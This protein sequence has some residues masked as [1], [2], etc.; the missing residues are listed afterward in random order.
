MKKFLCLGLTAA[1]V[2]GMTGCGSKADEPKMAKF[3]EEELTEAQ[4]YVYA[5]MDSYEIPDKEED[6]KEARVLL[7]DDLAADLKGKVDINAWDVSEIDAIVVAYLGDKVEDGATT[8]ADADTE[9]DWS[10]VVFLVGGEG[11]EVSYTKS[12]KSAKFAAT[13]VVDEAGDDTTA[14]A[15]AKKSIAQAQLDAEK[16]L[17]TNKEKLG[18]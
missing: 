4:Q 2:L 8:A 14:I 6:F 5:A 13:S 15:D 10:P 7:T 17:E 12:L 1:L 11:K 9:N 18:E 3:S 16:Y